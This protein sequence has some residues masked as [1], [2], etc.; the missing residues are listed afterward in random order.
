MFCGALFLFGTMSTSSTVKG[1]SFLTAY[2]EANKKLI[3]TLI[4]KSEISAY[5]LN[6]SIKQ[7][8]GDHTVDPYAP[9]TWKYYLN[10]A[11]QPH[12][13][14][15]YMNVIS[16]DTLETIEFTPENLK[17]HTATAEAYQFGTRYFYTLLRK[18]P[19][20]EAYIMG[21]LNPVDMYD[22]IYAENY[23]ILG[24]DK[25]LVEE[26]ER[27]LIED[28]ETYIKGYFSRWTV[29]GYQTTD[30]YYQLALHAVLS[31]HAFNRLLNLRQVRCH[32]NEAHSFHIREYLASHSG[33]DKYIPYLTLY[34]KLYL[35]R[36]IRYLE[37][38]SGSVDQFRELVY[39]LLTIRKV[40]LAEYTINQVSEFDDAK[41]TLSLAKKKSIGTLSNA[42]IKEYFEVPYVQDKLKPTVYGNPL[43]LESNSQ[44][45]HKRFKV[46]PSSVVQTKLLEST[47]VDYS[48]AVKDPFVDVLIKHWA[49]L[50][51]ND[52]YPVLIYFTDPMTGEYRNLS[53]KDAFIY[54][55]YLT[56]GTMGIHVDKIPQYTN[57][58]FRLISKPKLQELTKLIPK[59]MEHL[60]EIAQTILTRQ[61][62]IS[63]CKSVN[64][65]NSL[66]RDI[67]NECNWL[68][69]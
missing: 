27:T 12:F 63:E 58:K 36:N 2:L 61:P 65:F 14:D 6:E 8:Y 39:N 32:T 26:Q 11:G 10:L 45:E 23:S 7:K 51:H 53:A 50:S 29:P 30:S 38:H 24:Y 64:A 66:C 41:Y 52:L 16:L 34:Q 44:L 68:W 22:A 49:Y 4:V 37:H 9:E 1:N 20:Q 55:N 15:V 21:V 17:V 43:Y 18:Y 19:Q 35:Y 60:S 62:T 59:G 69:Y 54:F 31:T 5:L 42:T 3:Q 67:Y 46:S 13:T 33:L 28:L 48:G 56:L 47:M 25:S 57:V 40:P